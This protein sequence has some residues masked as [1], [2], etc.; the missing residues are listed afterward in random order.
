MAITSTRR[1]INRFETADGE[2]EL[3]SVK[4]AEN[5]TAP[6]DVDVLTLAIG[7]NTITPPTGAKGVTILFPA[8]NL[9]LVTLKGVTGDTGIVLHLTDPTSFG[10][11]SAASTFVLTAAAELVGVRLI[12]S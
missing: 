10:I 9:V 2:I 8:G 11:N 3:L 7:A 1:I 5:S 6:G 12:W 4:E